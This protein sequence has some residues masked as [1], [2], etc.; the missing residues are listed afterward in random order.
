MATRRAPT[1][2]DV[3]RE[4]GVG[5]AT[6]SRVLNDSPLV[7]VRTRA[8]VQEA[9]E[10]LGYR[11]NAAARALS[12]GRSHAV[13]VVAPFFTTHSVVERLRGVFDHLQARGYDLVLFDVETPAQRV[14]VLQDR[15]RLGRLA[16]LIVVSL[17]LDDDE[18][19]VL[20]GQLPVVLVDVGHPRLP[21]VLIDDVHGGELAG[22]HLL[23]R[24]HRRI[25]FIGDQPANPF[26]FASSERRRIGLHTALERAGAEPAQELERLGDHGL[27]PA[28]LLAEELLGVADPPTA[29]FA[30]SDIQAI[31]VLQAASALGARVPED[32]AVMGFDDIEMA[33]VVGLTTV[34]QPL[35]ATGARGAELVLAAIEGREPGTLAELQP[36]RVVER[37]T[38]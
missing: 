11:P 2:F 37:R 34:R 5:I 19:A 21:H 26:G 25:G 6:V 10:L 32:V 15:A 38:T 8:R 13:G 27:E 31:G 24:G 4:A 20:R 28:R 22:E 29:V 16:G 7:N 35:E 14:E 23:A 36:L 1:I 12:M 33:G 3:A 30:A 18:V 17:P 9:I